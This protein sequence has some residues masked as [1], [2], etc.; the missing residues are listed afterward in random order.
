MHSWLMTLIGQLERVA[1]EMW[2]L[3]GQKGRPIGGEDLFDDDDHA[4]K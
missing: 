2:E 3:T 4:S 1:D